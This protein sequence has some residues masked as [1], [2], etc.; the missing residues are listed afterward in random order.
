MLDETFARIERTVQDADELDSDKR[1]ELLKRIEDLR[2]EM[3]NLNEMH[4]NQVQSITGFTQVTTHEATRGD[5]NPNL[6]RAGLDGLTA[7]VEHFEATHPG[8]VRA[9]T[10]MSQLLANI[11]LG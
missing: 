2:A 3:G 11:G 1:A 10:S 5:K 9:V 6:V 4:H 8:L 7:S